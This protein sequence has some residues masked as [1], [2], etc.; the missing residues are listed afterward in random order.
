MRRI[1]RVSVLFLVVGIFAVSCSAAKPE[2]TIENLKEAITG[3]SNASATYKAFSEK[4]AEDGLLNISKMFAAA[5][6][7]EAIHVKNHN[8]VLVKLGEQAFTANLDMPTVSNCMIENIEAAI[9]G[10]TYEFTVMYPGFLTVANDEKAK[11]AI[12]SFT[13]AN[14]AEKTHANLYTKALNILKAT[15]SDET[16]SSTWYACPKCGDLFDTIQNVNSCPLCATSPASF[17]KF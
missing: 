7:A 3:E 4:A 15:G 16:V 9:E 17:L 1:V 12:T 11:D 10:E 5:S 6:E 14:D 13:W 2:K 8:A